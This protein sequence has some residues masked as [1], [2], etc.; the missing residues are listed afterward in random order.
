MNILII[1]NVFPPGFI[2]GYELGASEIASALAALGHE[3]KVLSTDYFTDDHATIHELSIERTLESM[4]L[5]HDWPDQ[6]DRQRKSVYINYSNIRRVGSVIRRFRP[7]VCLVFNAQGLGVLGLIHFLADCGIPSILYLMDNIFSGL[8]TESADFHVFRLLM[9]QL[10]WSKVRIIAMSQK[11]MD[12]VTRTIPAI[13]QNVTIVPGWIHSHHIDFITS[14]IDAEGP[15]RFVFSSRVAPHK[16][17]EM[18]V[19]AAESLAARRV[20]FV[21]DVFGLGWVAQ[22][23]QQVKSKN[24]DTHIHYRGGLGKSEMVRTFSEYHALLFPTWEREPFGF[25]VSE[26]AA[27]GCVP[28]MTSSIG[29][30]EWFIDGIDCM[31]I[32]RHADALADAMYRLVMMAPS[33]RL[34]MRVAAMD[35]ARRYLR[36]DRWLPQIE[37]VCVEAAATYQPRTFDQITQ[38]M[39]AYLCL[40]QLWNE[41][42][43]D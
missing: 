25:V 15:V 24:L 36:F 40:G 12:E 23:V 17:T 30:S 2:G 39:T 18:I 6:V 37:E 32:A 42:R 16:G 1:S 3:V 26:A 34:G 8:Q 19:S 11:V 5:S 10:D 14:P 4:M 43:G 29:A 41:R 7:E 27:M 28:I 35:A 33:E 38:V 9:G 20:P 21:I 22:F 31:K 13:P